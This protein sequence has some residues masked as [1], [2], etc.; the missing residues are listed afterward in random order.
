MRAAAAAA[1]TTFETK[2]CQTKTCQKERV[3]N[4]GVNTRRWGEGKSRDELPPFPDRKSASRAKKNSFPRRGSITCTSTSQRERRRRVT[5]SFPPSSFRESTSPNPRRIVR[6][7]S[8]F[9]AH[10]F[11]SVFTLQF[12]SP[13]VVRS[14]III[15]PISFSI[16]LM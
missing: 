15:N 8:H 10:P 1:A 14:T 3:P 7:F 5:L 11:I 13:I 12:L 6:T 2:T 4:G 16:Y 9:I